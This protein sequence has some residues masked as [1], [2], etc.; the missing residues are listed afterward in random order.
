[1]SLRRAWPQCRGQTAVEYLVACLLV[2]ALLAV[3]VGDSSSV[4]QLALRS[5]HMGFI[6]FVNALSVP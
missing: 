6:R 1:V 3:P 2:A 4:A 5:I